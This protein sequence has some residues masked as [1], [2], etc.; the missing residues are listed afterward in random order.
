MVSQPNI[1]ATVTLV[2]NAVEYFRDSH[3]VQ[4]MDD[5]KS[6][7]QNLD[8]SKTEDQ[9]KYIPGP[10]KL[11]SD[12]LRAELAGGEAEKLAKELVEVATGASRASDR[13]A[14]IAE[15]TDRTEGKAVQNHKHAGI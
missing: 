14:A 7:V 9:R 4:I 12:A 5:T 2:S 13:I 10:R 1:P 3:S 11:I 8:V 6:N 15:I